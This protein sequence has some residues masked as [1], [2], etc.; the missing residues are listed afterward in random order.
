MLSTFPC[1]TF[2]RALANFGL[3]A[4][5]H[6]VNEFSYCGKTKWANP[7]KYTKVQSEHKDCRN[8]KLVKN[9]DNRPL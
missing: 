1:V 5:S 7:N 2:S 6:C 9:N 3:K 8:M 4:N